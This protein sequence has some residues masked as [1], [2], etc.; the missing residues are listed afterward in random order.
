MRAALR[1]QN[2]EAT[3]TDVATR[4]RLATC[5]A[6]NLRKV[7][8][9]HHRDKESSK[10]TSA[11][12]QGA[13]M[14]HLGIILA[15]ATLGFTT[16]V[17]AQICCSANCVPNYNPPRCVPT[18]VSSGT[19][20]QIQCGNP[21]PPPSGGTGGRDTY[22]APRIPPP[23]CPESYPNPQSRADATNQC[24]AT[25]SGN[26]QL[27]S[28][29]FEDD[30]GRAEDQRTGLS[31]P[32][33]QRALANQCRSRCERYVASLYFCSEKNEVWQRAFGDIGGQVYGSA[34]VDL[35][36]PRLRTSIGNLIRTRPSALQTQRS[37]R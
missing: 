20:Y 30:A 3:G 37:H 26:A 1:H 15:V 11:T 23:Y 24:I 34:R 25:L 36:G 28:C 33:R 31:C 32:D 21:P 22:V 16:P 29:W 6:Y 19:C 4:R 17:F 18:G 35:C 14:K 27:W 5:P 13:S 10:D 2:F 7:I 12:Q 8:R 9:C